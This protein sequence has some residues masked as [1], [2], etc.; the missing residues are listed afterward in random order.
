MGQETFSPFNSRE[1]LISLLGL[2]KKYR[3]KENPVVYK[4]IIEHLW[5]DVLQVPINPGP[6]K[7]AIRITQ[8]LGIFPLFRNLKLWWNLLQELI[9]RKLSMYLKIYIT[10]F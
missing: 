10:K 8:Y 3:R 5:P 1:L 4:K 6:K 2:P 7:I 9:I